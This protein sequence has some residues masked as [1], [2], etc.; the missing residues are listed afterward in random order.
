MAYYLAYLQL[1]L[2]PTYG[3]VFRQGMV[4]LLNEK[5]RMKPLI[6]RNKKQYGPNCKITNKNIHRYKHKAT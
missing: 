5:A 4:K 3:F 6:K 1:K 2:L